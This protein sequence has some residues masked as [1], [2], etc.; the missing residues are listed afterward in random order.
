MIGFGEIVSHTG[1]DDTAETP[2]FV[3]LAAVGMILWNNWGIPLDSLA[4]LFDVTERSVCGVVKDLLS[5]K[6]FCVE[7]MRLLTSRFPERSHRQTYVGS[8]SAG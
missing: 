3:T 5:G 4:A 2:R 8:S 1:T 6:R 7:Y